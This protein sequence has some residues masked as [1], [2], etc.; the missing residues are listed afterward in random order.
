MSHGGGGVG[1]VLKSVPYYL[2]GP[3]LHFINETSKTTINRQLIL[4]YKSKI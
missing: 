3:L 2:N 4:L 1:K